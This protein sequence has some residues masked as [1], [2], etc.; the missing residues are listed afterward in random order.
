MTHEYLKTG[1]EYIRYV[2][3]YQFHQEIENI[4][5]RILQIY[6]LQH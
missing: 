6:F 1:Y 2:D 5:K 4:Y 3:H